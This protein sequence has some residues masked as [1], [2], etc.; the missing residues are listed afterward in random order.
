M[1]FPHNVEPGHVFILVF[2][3][4]MALLGIN[5]RTLFDVQFTRTVAEIRLREMQEREERE[6]RKEGDVSFAR[7]GTPE[8]RCRARGAEAGSLRAQDRREADHAAHRYPVAAGQ[9]FNMGRGG[10]GDGRLRHVP[11]RRSGRRK[12]KLAALLACLLATPCSSQTVTL[13]LVGGY[14]VPIN[15]IEGTTTRA[16]GG[17]WDLLN[18]KWINRHGSSKL[19][20]EY[21][22]PAEGLGDPE[23]DYESWPLLVYTGRNADPFASV[24]NIGP[25]GVIWLD[26]DTVLCSGRKSYRSGYVGTWMCTH[27]IE[28]GAETLIN[29]DDPGVDENDNFHRCQAFGSGFCRI[30]QPFADSYCDGRTIGAGRGGYD[31]LNS[32]S[33]PAMSAL[34]YEATGGDKIQVLLDHP[35]NLPGQPAPRSPDYTIARVENGYLDFW[36]DPVGS[37]P[38]DGRWIAGDCGNPAWVPGV[39]LFFPVRQCN[40]TMDYRAQGDSGSLKYFGV[41][42]TTLFYSANSDGNRGDHQSDT[43]L[44]DYPDAIPLRRVY[45]YSEAELAE[46]AQGTRDAWTCTP[47]IIDFPE[48][49]FTWDNSRPKATEL[50]G[51]YWDPTRNYLWTCIYQVWNDNTYAV[52]AAY[53]VRNGGFVRSLAII[54][55]LLLAGHAMAAAP[56]ITG[57]PVTT[58]TAF[59][60]GNINLPGTIAANDL[61]IVVWAND[62]GNQNPALTGFTRLDSGASVHAVFA[63][64]ATGSEGATV[65]F[66]QDANED[67]AAIAFRI[68]AAEWTQDLADVEAAYSDTDNPP[69]LTPTGGA[70]D[71]LFIATAGNGAGATVSTWPT[72]YTANQNEHNTGG[73]SNNA[74]VAFATKATTSATSDD[75]S[76]WAW[77]ETMRFVACILALAVGSA[78][79]ADTPL[80]QSTAVTVKLGP[81]VDSTNGVTAETSLTISQADV[82]LSKAGGDYAQKNESSAATHDELGEYDVDLD[83]TD[84][85]TLGPLRVM[86]QESGALPVWRDFVVMPANVYDSLYSTDKLQVDAVEFSSSSSAADNAETAFTGTITSFDALDTAQD[87]EHNATQTLIGVT[88]VDLATTVAAIEGDT[89]ELQTDWAN[90]GRLD[91]ILDTAASGSDPAILTTTIDGLTNQTTFS[92]TTGSADDDAYN[93]WSVLIIDQ[94]TST[95]VASGVISDYTGTGADVVLDED[96]GVF[97]IATGDTVKIYRPSAVEGTVTV[98]GTV[99]ATV[100]GTVSA[101]VV[102][103]LGTAPTETTAGNL[104]GNFSVFYDNADAA[105]TNTVDDVGGGSGLDAAGVRA[106]VGLAAANLD[107]QL[108][109][110]V[111]DTAEIGAAGAGLTAVPYNSA[112]DA[113]IQSEATDALNA[114]DG[115]TNAELE[116]RTVASGS[117][118][119]PSADEVDLGSVKGTALT[120]T[121]GGN[122]ADNISF[123]Y[124]LDTTTTKT[125]NDVGVAGSGLTQADVRSAIGLASA[126][127][128]TQLATA[129][130]DLDTITGSDGVTLATTQGNYAPA[131]AAALTTVATNVSSILTDTAEIGAAGAGLSAIPWNSSWDAET[132]SEVND[133]LVAI[134]LDHLLAVEYDPASKPGVGTALLNETVW[135]NSGVSIWNVNVTHMNETPLIG[136]GVTADNTDA[137]SEDAFDFGD[138]TPS[139]PATIVSSKTVAHILAGPTGRYITVYFVANGATALYGPLTVTAESTN[140]SRVTV[141]SVTDEGA[142]TVNGRLYADGDVYSV[143]ATAAGPDTGVTVPIKFRVQGTGYD[144]P[145]CVDI[146][147]KVCIVKL[148]TDYDE[149]AVY[150][151]AD[152]TG[153]NWEKYYHANRLNP[154]NAGAPRLILGSLATCPASMASTVTDTETPTASESATIAHTAAT[155]NGTW[156]GPVTVDSVT[157]HY[158]SS[159]DGA[160]V[161]YSI[162][163]PEGGGIEWRSVF[164]GTVGSAVDVTITLGGGSIDDDDW[165]VGGSG[166][167]RTV[168][169]K[170][171]SLLS[172]RIPLAQHL[173]A[174]TYTV[175]CTRAGSGTDRI[176][177]HSLVATDPVGDWL[178][179]DTEGRRGWWSAVT[180]GSDSGYRL[181]QPGFVLYKVTETDRILWYAAKTSSSGIVYVEIFDAN[182]DAVTPN[183]SDLTESG[184]RY[185]IDM[186]AASQ[187]IADWELATGLTN[188]TYWV[189]IYGGAEKNASSSDT[190]INEISISGLNSS[191]PGDIST[192]RIF[193]TAASTFCGSGNQEYASKPKQDIGSPPANFV[194][195]THGYESDATSLVVSVDSTPVDYAGAAAGDRFVG[196]LLEIEAVT[197]VYFYGTATK[198]IEMTYGWT[199]QPRGHRQID[200]TREIVRS[201]VEMGTEYVGIVQGAAGPDGL[202][203]AGQ[204]YLPLNGGASLVAA[205]NSAK[206]VPVTGQAQ[207]GTNQTLGTGFGILGP[208]HLLAC[209]VDDASDIGDAAVLSS[210]VRGIATDR[211]DGQCKAYTF[212]SN[213]DAYTAIANEDTLTVTSRYW[214][215]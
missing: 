140:T 6:S 169:C 183:G 195:G 158:Y 161:E 86:V 148:R 79:L 137:F 40:N 200:V 65:A 132:Q 214:L 157:D 54:A 193:D 209:Q 168:D 145:H 82:R 160:Y 102:E 155:T 187:T 76:T 186:Y 74:S 43:G 90:G 211:S 156:T 38:L 204:D 110:I 44:Q 2:L 115:P 134:H 113:E 59:T 162:A 64:K 87:T 106:A 172:R 69:S 107:T 80:K 100:S 120:E 154:S 133:A 70:A 89:D 179:N 96:P 123:F 180:I 146:E 93:G 7:T 14:R 33:G 184:G 91:L 213:D 196:A 192:D 122:L 159:T 42:D 167:T 201:D 95:Q 171:G 111:T 141:G 53:R 58:S 128:D 126:N 71:Y 25:G 150:V 22:E 116:A 151:P 207:A 26:A 10:G 29:M 55:A 164:N 48:G 170:G 36:R 198:C 166:D 124:D 37:G 206:P 62:G 47:Q 108:S 19:V 32:P 73:S 75:P 98:D 61:L 153:V 85:A 46:V 143:V 212:A 121:T 163:V 130:A 191:S 81:F 131:T 39:G 18:G 165:M 112:W 21:T 27:N 3:F 109:A 1:G 4:G 181:R 15:N 104:A 203:L 147:R 34:D 177:N 12:M 9:V 119:D 188:G 101:N 94:S 142:A 20:V 60:A 56:T 197:D 88:A 189:L 105:T 11:D 68:L 66:T 173:P 114:Y 24:E 127:L 83:T 35:Y 199:Y 175:R 45:I 176:Y 149:F 194:T 28:T 72:G 99:T 67:V 51:M 16:L 117:Y 129:Q 174:G 77:D 30:P 185:S 92:L 190:L 118:F 63:K 97:T 5:L 41:G 202:T 103:I 31:V 215:G 23:D 152:A 205:S 17:C 13:T 8:P 84:T 135:N 125:V 136:T 138:E 208:Q 57:T 182:G 139:E 78:A 210:G 178:S 49:P 52:M 144:Q 50:A